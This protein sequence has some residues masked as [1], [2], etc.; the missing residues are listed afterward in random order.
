[1]TP[2]YAAQLGA[3][4]W[5]LGTIN[6]AASAVVALA[7]LVA[8][9]RLVPRFG[10]RRV[11]LAGFGLAT[12]AWLFPAAGSPAALTFCQ[13]VVSAGTGSAFPTLMALSIQTVPESR[14]ATAMGFFQSLY[15]L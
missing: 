5:Q 7:G 2:V 15:A 3:T 8:G 6:F 14:R 4:R 13:M 12:A 10:G 1:F 9:S 11:V